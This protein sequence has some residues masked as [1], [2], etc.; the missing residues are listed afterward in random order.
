MRTID[1]VKEIR[2]TEEDP[3]A[4]LLLELCETCRCE[5]RLSSPGRSV[6]E[7]ANLGVFSAHHASHQP[8]GEAFASDFCLR[9]FFHL[10]A[11]DIKS[12]EG[13][14][15]RLEN[16]IA[17]EELSDVSFDA[18][19]AIL[20]IVFCLFRCGGFS[21]A[22][23]TL[24]HSVRALENAADEFSVFGALEGPLLKIAKSTRVLRFEPVGNLILRSFSHT[25]LVG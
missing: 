17:L 1:E 19:E 6:E 5:V 4:A 8:R 15:C 12:V 16:L 3:G 22:L 21:C 25:G 2:D 20:S 10:S 14:I 7:K 11:R 13:P 23:W 24:R 9:F 18:T